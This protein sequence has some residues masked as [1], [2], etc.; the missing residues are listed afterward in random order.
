MDLDA[1]LPGAPLADTKAFYKAC[2]KV[3]GQDTHVSGGLSDTGGCFV[4]MRSTREDDTS[5]PM[6]RAMRKAADQFTGT[7]PAFIALQEH[8]LT[9]A[10]LMLPNVRRQVGIL[11]YALFGH[12]GGDHV[13]MTYVTAFGAVVKK[14]ERL[15]TPAFAVPNPQP[16]FP[17]VPSAAG[18][19]FSTVPDAEFAAAIGA[20]LPAPNISY[21]QIDPG[22]RE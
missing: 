1:V 11:S 4:V 5:A 8:G 17:I 14:G 19:F 6:L 3:F 12:Y 15:F 2:G 10:D 20:P 18:P 7:R 22:E 9:A 21:L 13:N 16:R